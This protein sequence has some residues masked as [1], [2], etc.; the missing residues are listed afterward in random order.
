MIRIGKD[1]LPLQ[2]I[3]QCFPSPVDD[4]TREYVARDDGSC[5]EPETR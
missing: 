1:S 4:G 3:F 2:I 5:S